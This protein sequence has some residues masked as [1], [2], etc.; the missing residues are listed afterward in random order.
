MPLVITKDRV[1]NPGKRKRTRGVVRKR[2]TVAKRTN[3]R[4]V[5]QTS[6]STTAAINAL[7]RKLKAIAPKKRRKK[8]NAKKRAKPRKKR[9]GVKR[10]KR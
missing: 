4:K 6:P 1:C 3:K 10:R 8:A 7:F 9:T 5:H 2:R